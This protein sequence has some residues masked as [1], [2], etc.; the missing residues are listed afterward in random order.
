MGSKE[1]KSFSPFEFY[2]KEKKT[3]FLNS[4]FGP[5]AAVIKETKFELKY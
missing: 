3:I 5:V 2:V 4:V 1:H